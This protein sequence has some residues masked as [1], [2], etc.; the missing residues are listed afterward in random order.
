V[1]LDLISNVLSHGDAGQKTVKQE[2]IEFE[3]DDIYTAEH[4]A[5]FDAIA[6]KRTSESP[7]SEAL[8]SM[9]VMEASIRSWKTG[10]RV[11][12]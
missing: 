2:T 3:R 7:L 5:F 6:G 8:Q 11:E 4:Q 10:V 9:K 12:L 1:Y